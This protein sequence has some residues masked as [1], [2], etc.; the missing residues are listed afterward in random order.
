MVLYLTLILFILDHT[1]FPNSLNPL[2]NG[3]YAKM[4]F[5][6]MVFVVLI[7]SSQY[8]RIRHLSC[9]PVLPAINNALISIFV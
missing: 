4:K 9:F 8:S 7:I 3:I 6:E 5:L 2:K 1:H